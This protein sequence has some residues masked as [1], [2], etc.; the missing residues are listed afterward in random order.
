MEKV[1]VIRTPLITN[2]VH[3]DQVVLEK[4]KIIKLEGL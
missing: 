1:R 3:L 4:Y 2:V